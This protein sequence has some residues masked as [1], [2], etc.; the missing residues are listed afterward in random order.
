ME[1]C[2]IIPV[3]NVTVTDFQ[4]AVSESDFVDSNRTWLDLIDPAI[5]KIQYLII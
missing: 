1:H 3:E 2:F 5:L 4:S